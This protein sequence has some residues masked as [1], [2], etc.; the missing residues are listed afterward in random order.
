MTC[1]SSHSRG[2]VLAALL[3]ALAGGLVVALATKA[4]PKIAAGMMQNMMARMKETCCN[5][6]EMCQC[7]RAGF[8]E[9]PEQEAHD[10]RV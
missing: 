1:I 3:G 6:A 8:G 2:Y 10:A 7:M 5:S 4:A 9:A